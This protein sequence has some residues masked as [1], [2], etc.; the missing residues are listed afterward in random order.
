MLTF[1]ALAKN[2]CLSEKVWP[3]LFFVWLGYVRDK[4]APQG[5]RNGL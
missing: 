4:R 3:M 1:P 5:Y 2:T